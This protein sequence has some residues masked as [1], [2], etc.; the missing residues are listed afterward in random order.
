MEKNGTG[1]RAGNSSIEKRLVKAMRNAAECSE[2]QAPIPQ[3]GRHAAPNLGVFT[4]NRCYGIFR[5]GRAITNCVCSTKTSLSF[6]KD[7]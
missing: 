5:E 3:N 4:C 6:V 1:S 2:C 7:M